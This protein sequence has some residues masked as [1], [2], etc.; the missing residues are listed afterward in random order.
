MEKG[1]SVEIVGASRDFT[2]REKLAIKELGNAV[3]IDTAL[4]DETDSLLIAP[5]D[6][7]VLEIHN[8]KAKGQ[9][10][11]KKYVVFDTNGT[12][13]VT[14]SESFF[15]NFIDIYETMKVEAPDEDY[16]IEC[17]KRPSKNY[18]GKNFISCSM[19]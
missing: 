1:Y 5:A 13:Y 17:Y 9:K 8:D 14:G 15:R 19:V 18:T 16:Q 3:G 10:D 4:L 6:Y 11:Y 7:A 12:K 2:V